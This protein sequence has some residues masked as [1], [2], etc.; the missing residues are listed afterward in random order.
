MRAELCLRLTGCRDLLLHRA[1]AEKARSIHLFDFE[2][3][4][5]EVQ[6]SKMDAASLPVEALSE[7]GPTCECGVEYKDSDTLTKMQVTINIK[8]M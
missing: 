2:P 5:I 3:K 1:G 8:I 4:T 7:R 6:R